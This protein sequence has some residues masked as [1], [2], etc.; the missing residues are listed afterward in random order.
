MSWGDARA[1]AWQVASEGARQPV[2]TAMGSVHAAAVSVRQAAMAMA[3]VASFG[4]RAAGELVGDAARGVLHASEQAL[5]R[6]PIAGPAYK[7]LK[8]VLS[9]VRPPG[10]AI[11]TP[12][13]NSLECKRRRLEQR[14]QLIKQGR[15]PE[16]SPA[17]KAAAE[18]LA[19][20]N[21]AVELARLSDDT[22]AQYGQPPVNQPPLGWNRI[23]NATLEGMGIDKR[24]L[25]KS[26]AVIYQTP[27]DWP[28]GHKTVLAFRGTVPSDSDDLKTNLD[29]AMGKETVQYQAATKLGR[30]IA[31]HFGTDVT[32]TGHSLGGGKAQA[33]G[34]AGKLKG[35][36]FNAAGLH[37]DTVSGLMPA[38]SQFLQYRSM[39]DPLTAVQNSAALQSALAGTAGVIGMPLGTGMALGQFITG[40]LGLPSLGQDAA[41]LAGKAAASPVLGLGNLVNHG[42]LLPPAHG[43]RVEVAALTDAGAALA[44][45]DLDGQHSVHGLIN[46][47]EQEKSQDIATLQA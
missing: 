6:H 3:N 15:V 41:D 45:T 2:T 18:R 4:G 44:S 26:K 7:M 42:Y 39:D 38:A 9:P 36:M 12:C 35:M 34:S 13:M 19:R 20:N 43:Q 1:S 21:E 46:G 31:K 5:Q 27:A 29:Q 28:G 24:L 17:Q 37:P 32:V 30:A 8:A 23:D 14:Q 47:I 16:A 33:A 40:Q 11:V 22:Y 10:A 25:E